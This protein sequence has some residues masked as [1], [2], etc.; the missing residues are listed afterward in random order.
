MTTL[1]LAAETT[2]VHVVLEVTIHTCLAQ[3][4][5]VARRLL[6]TIVAGHFH[7][8]AIQHKLRSVVIE[9]PGFPGT[10]VMTGLALDAK[11]ALVL[12]VLFMASITGGWRIMECRSL[13]ALLA[14]SSGVTAS[15]REAR[16]VV[17]I[18]GILPALF[19][20]TSFA[21]I[22]ELALVLVI[23]AVAGNALARQSGLVIDRPLLGRMTGIALG[24]DM[25]TLQQVFGF[26]IMI[27][28]AGLPVFRRVASLAL[29]AI[30]AF[31]TLV[32]IVLAVTGHAFH[33]HLQLGI[34][35]RNP[36]LVAS[37]ALGILVFVA[38]HKMGIVMIET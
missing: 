32:I 26:S 30:T 23:L 25:F 14:L 4:D 19:V 27:E 16:F 3:F 21:L 18:R 31:V 9:I 33:I 28:G 1:A 15:Q 17:V 10:G 7:M 5:R 20:V 22:A 24:L 6:M 13:M 12:V 2:I 35:A 38:Q 34:R 29:C 11:A 36:T 37:I 8:P